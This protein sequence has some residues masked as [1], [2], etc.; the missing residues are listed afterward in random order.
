[1][2]ACVGECLA[3]NLRH[4]VY[5]EWLMGDVNYISHFIQNS[6]LEVDGAQ[7]PTGHHPCITTNP[8]S[9]QLS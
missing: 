8:A 1:M 9:Y 7:T 2:W 6:A 4:K 3:H 5:T